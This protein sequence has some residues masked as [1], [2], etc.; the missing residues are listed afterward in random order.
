MVFSIPL[1]FTDLRLRI[2]TPKERGEAV[3]KITSAA[4]TGAA[5][6]V[7]AA[8]LVGGAAVTAGSFAAAQA[9][10]GAGLVS[11]G[12]QIGAAFAVKG[13]QVAFSQVAPPVRRFG[14]RI[15]SELAAST[16]FEMDASG[17]AQK[18]STITVTPAT[19]AAI[20]SG[21]SPSGAPSQCDCSLPPSEQSIL[22]RLRCK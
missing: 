17:T 14:A 13:A 16:S 12:V 8:V 10:R 2:A 5:A 15:Q 4:K 22:C 1:P 11:T 19:L 7:G 9:A 3:A 21:I 6:L 18:I 20:R